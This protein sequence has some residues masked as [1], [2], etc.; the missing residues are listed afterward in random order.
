MRIVTYHLIG[1]PHGNEGSNIS[2]DLVPQA[3]EASN[4]SSDRVPLGNE[5]SYI[6]IIL[7]S[8]PG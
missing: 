8:A 4:I 3:N 7:F 6:I 5:G 1:V 2:S